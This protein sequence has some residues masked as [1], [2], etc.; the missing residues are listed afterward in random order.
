MHIHHV[1]D[2][3]AATAIEPSTK[4]L[5][6]Y[7]YI[8]I[9]LICIQTNLHVDVIVVSTCTTFADFSFMVHCDLHMLRC[10]VER[11]NG[12]TRTYLI[13]PDPPEWQHYQWCECFYVLRLV[14]S[15]LV[16]AL[17]KSLC[18]MFAQE[19]ADKKVWCLE[20][21]ADHSSGRAKVVILSF[22]N[23]TKTWMSHLGKGVQASFQTRIFEVPCQFS[24]RYQSLSHDGSCL[25]GETWLIGILYIHF[26]DLQ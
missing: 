3:P 5:H 18:W 9:F 4:N 1:S 19:P 20:M 15:W 22:K 24:G 26:K 25:D 23:H 17:V 7:I 2:P 10:F 12:P 13:L 8:F 6:I 16:F 21:P 14:A 11:A